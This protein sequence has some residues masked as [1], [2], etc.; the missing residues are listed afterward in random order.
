MSRK[1][2]WTEEENRIL[3]NIVTEHIRM[4]ATKTAAFKKAA[5]ILGRTAGACSY[6]WNTVLCKKEPREAEEESPLLLLP[7]PKVDRDLNVDDIIKYLQSLKGSSLEELREENQL[8]IKQQE[9]LKNRQ[10]TLEKLFAEKKEKYR[11]L[12][13]RYEGITKSFEKEKIL[14]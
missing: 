13:E 14:H 6:R 8:L 4:G 7:P 10:T 3:A 1:N 2:Q 5:S 9:E 12:F 11:Q